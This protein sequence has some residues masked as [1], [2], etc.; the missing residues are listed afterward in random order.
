MTNIHL[1]IHS[2]THTECLAKTYRDKEDQDLLASRE[3]P[4]LHKRHGGLE[5]G[6]DLKPGR[7]YCPSCLAYPA[8]RPTSSICRAQDKSTDGTAVRTNYHQSGGSKQKESILTQFWI[9]EIWNQG[10][11]KVL[12]PLK[13]LAE[14]PYYLFQLPG[15]PGVLGLGQ[16]LP[17]YGLLRCVSM[18]SPLL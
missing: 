18:S 13:T 12:F 8:A 3:P 15:E 2:L 6:P 14:N 7:W 16:P 5:Q 10:V 11:T 9:Q 1:F 17:A 4:V